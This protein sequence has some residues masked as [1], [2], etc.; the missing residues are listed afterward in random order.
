MEWTTKTSQDYNEAAHINALQD[1]KVD[2]DTSWLNVKDFGAKGDGVTDDTV[3]IQAAIDVARVNPFRT[4]YFPSGIY[5]ISDSLDITGTGGGGS[6]AIKIEGE[7]SEP[8]YGAIIRWDGANDRA[9]LDFV[10]SHGSSMKNIVIE[11]PVGAPAMVGVLHGRPGAGV[12]AGNH[13]WE[14]VRVVGYFLIASLYEATSESNTFIHVKLQN[15]YDNAN[16]YV[17]V[18]TGTV[19]FGVTSLY[20][21]LT[22]WNG[23]NSSLWLGGSMHS[24]GSAVTSAVYLSDINNLKIQNLNFYGEGSSIIQLEGEITNFVLDSIRMEAPDM[25]RHGIHFIGGG[26]CY[27][28]TV[29][30][31]DLI[32]GG[33]VNFGAVYGDD[34][35]QFHQIHLEDCRIPAG[36]ANHYLIN[37]DIITDGIVDL[38]LGYKVNVRATST[39]VRYKNAVAGQIT[40]AG[41][42]RGNTYHGTYLK[43][44]LVW[45]P[46]NLIDGAGEVSGVVTVTGA[47]VG[48]GVRVF[49]PYSTQGIIY[50]GTVSAADSVLISLF[51]KTGGAIDL[52]SASW[53]VKVYE[54]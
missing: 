47:T 23:N 29:K 25:L 30:N 14:N 38:G 9:M 20:R 49:P 35:E 12:S 10:G 18:R 6:T 4:I 33:N 5:L 22:A 50:S 8:V 52:G 51:N 53:K 46:G 7:I 48:D 27:N 32:G 37:A 16:A 40:I 31:S 1:E 3:A 13:Y 17:Y 34:T 44:S 11:A 24:F 41:T 15:Y 43:G 39:S 28:L 21:T 19:I 45:D 54:Y 2:K 36:D 26:W 42:G